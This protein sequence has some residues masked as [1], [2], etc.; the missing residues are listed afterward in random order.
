MISPTFELRLKIDNILDFG[1]K[2]IM[3]ILIEIMDKIDCRRI[4]FWHNEIKSYAVNTFE[5][6]WGPLLTE[7][8]IIFKIQDNDKSND[9]VWFDILTKEDNEKN[10]R[11]RFKCII[12][13]NKTELIRALFSYHNTLT[14]V[15]GSVGKRIKYVKE[16]TNGSR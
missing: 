12:N 4:I 8:N 15:K 16:T 10:F 6:R 5:E 11:H 7:K 13:N 1:E 3:E 9:Y 14:F 2:D